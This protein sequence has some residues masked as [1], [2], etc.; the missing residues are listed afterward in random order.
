MDTKDYYRLDM[1]NK[2]VI[3]VTEVRRGYA[4]GRLDIQP[5]ILNAHG[6]VHGGALFA[7]ADTV[8]GA[9]AQAT[10]KSVVTM[11][12]DINFLRP[13]IHGNLICEAH[14]MTSGRT[15]GVYRTEVTDEDGKI[16]CIATFTMH[17]VVKKD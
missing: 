1:L 4:K 3:R 14:E 16:L 15:I 10:G 13:G 5:E 12:G 11:S 9:C 6:F 8:A 7:L 17:T 2:S